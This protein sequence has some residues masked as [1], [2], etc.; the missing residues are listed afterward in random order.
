MKNKKDCNDCAG[1]AIGGG[2]MIG[3]GVG[4]IFLEASPLYF[5]ASIMLGI[6]IGLFIASYISR[7]K[8]K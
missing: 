3:L 7:D 4:F 2:T 6:G 1:L 5:V 8:K